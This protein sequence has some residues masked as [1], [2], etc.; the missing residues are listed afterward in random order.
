MI[1]FSGRH[2]AEGI[3]NTKISMY[4]TVG[5]NILNIILNYLLIFGKFGF[6]ALGAYG[7]AISTLIVRSVMAIC[8]IG[9][10]CF[11]HSF[12]RY[13]LFFS[14]AGFLWVR[15]KELIR[16]STPVALQIGMEM[17]AFAFCAIMVGWVDGNSLAAHQITLS[18]AILTFMIVLGIS[19]ATTIRVSHQLGAGNF[20]GARK[21]GFAS[22]HLALG[23][24]AITATCFIVFRNHIPLLFN[25]EPEV[26]AIAAKL[27]IAAGLFQVFDGLQAVSMAGLRGLA[28]T[29]KPMLISFISYIIV[30]LSVGYILAFVVGLEAF[31]IWLG[32][33]VGLGLAATWLALRFHKKSKQ[34]L[35]SSKIYQT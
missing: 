11:N 29:A 5:C 14:R 6:P 32:F 15:I 16:I 22:M 19:S 34:L 27:F 28:D 35:L 31:G 9:V 13:L 10:F 1:F 23:F 20:V 24:M 26:V 12:R 8:F 17:F 3:G 7:A 2:F 18:M 25:N 33:V 21:A 30:C 4:I